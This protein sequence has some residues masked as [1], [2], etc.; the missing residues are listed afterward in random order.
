MYIKYSEPE[1]FFGDHQK[2]SNT[3]SNGNPA[4]ARRGI[5]AR[6]LI[7]D[8]VEFIEPICNY[9]IWKITINGNL[10]YLPSEEL[11]SYYAKFDERIGIISKLE[12]CSIVLPSVDYSIP[13]LE[14]E[15]F[16]AITH[17][18]SFVIKEY[19]DGYRLNRLDSSTKKYTT[20]KDAFID[21]ES[22]LYNEK[23]NLV[24]GTT[25]KGRCIKFVEV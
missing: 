3:L 6:L 21:I 9:A 17:N 18:K 7:N 2:I 23:Y 24:K 1:A 19:Y 5:L 12:S 25:T 15:E 14:Y 20:E 11:W 16:T 8:I 10:L 13:T 22:K 4:T